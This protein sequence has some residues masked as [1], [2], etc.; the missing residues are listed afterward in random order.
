MNER[1][2]L[3]EGL[4]SIP[5]VDPRLEKDFVYQAKSTDGERTPQPVA[6]STP[7]PHPPIARAPISTRIRAEMAAALK[8]ASLERQLAGIEPYTLQDI[9]EAAIEPWLK[10][11]D[12]LV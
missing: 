12:Y 2:T 11:H 8:R 6:T 9:L 4:K 5:P 10:A 1:R 3:L 7:T